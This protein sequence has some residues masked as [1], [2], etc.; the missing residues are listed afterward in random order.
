M[1]KQLKFIVNLFNHSEIGQMSLQD[2]VAIIAHQLRA[3]GHICEWDN[4]RFIEGYDGY[5]II[6]E[7]FTPG[8]IEIVRRAREQRNSRF[9]Y[10]CTEEPTDVGGFN[11]DHRGDMFRRQQI[12]PE[13]AQYCDAILALVP[14][15]ETWYGQFAPAAHIELGYAPTL[16]KKPPKPDYIYGFYGSLTFRRKSILRKIERRYH[17]LGLITNRADMW[18]PGDDRVLRLVNT[19]LPRDERDTAMQR[20]RIIVQIR[21]N[22]KMGLVSSSRCANALHFGRAVIAEPHAHSHPWDQVVKFSKTS[23]S[24]IEDCINMRGFWE[25]LYDSQFKRFKEIMSPQNCLGRRLD[26]MDIGSNLSKY[27]PGFSSPQTRMVSGSTI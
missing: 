15:A 23:D 8:S 2:P 12:F 10:I 6:V 13:A 5:N 19:F 26:E 20:A 18:K 3:L 25:S 1:R 7:G 17:G 22:D 16:V 27:I 24:F 11:H 14:G 9:I 21:L 4:Q